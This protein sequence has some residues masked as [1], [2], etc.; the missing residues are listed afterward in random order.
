MPINEEHAS[1]LDEVIERVLGAVTPGMTAA[2][3][4]EQ[5]QAMEDFAKL[6]LAF[7]ELEVEAANGDAQ[8]ANR[9][10]AAYGLTLQFI[11]RDP[12]RTA[13]ALR[14]STEMFA[15]VLANAWGGWPEALAGTQADGELF[16]EGSG[17]NG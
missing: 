1:K 10:A 13:A 15:K 5:A 4:R 16:P 2:V 9:I 14:M 12:Q 6:V 3:D 11:K 7:I 8:K 17:L